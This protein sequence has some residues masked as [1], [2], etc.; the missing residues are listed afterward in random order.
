MFMLIK[1]I[2]V[3]TVISKNP[4]ALPLSYMNPLQGNHERTRT[5]T[6]QVPNLEGRKYIAT[7]CN[8]I[9]TVIQ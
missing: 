4:G 5:V 9:N 2:I 3:E 8:V 6:P 7:K 1:T